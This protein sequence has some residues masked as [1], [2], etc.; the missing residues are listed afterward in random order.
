M[1]LNVQLNL[2]ISSCYE[3]QN[4]LT[5]I[6]KERGRRFHF[7]S[8]GLVRRPSSSTK[9]PN[10]AKKRNELVHNNNNNNK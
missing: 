2:K 1:K 10:S 9:T 7:R 3:K 6:P 8:H 5:H 4:N